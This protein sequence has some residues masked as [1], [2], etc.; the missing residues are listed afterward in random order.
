MNAV[1]EPHW[2]GIGGC[3]E[4]EMRCGLRKLKLYP[5]YEEALAAA[6]EWNQWY[7]RKRPDGDAH[8]DIEKY[9]RS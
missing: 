6:I 4:I 1:N 7:R 3:S 9:Q 2:T 8:C 5:S